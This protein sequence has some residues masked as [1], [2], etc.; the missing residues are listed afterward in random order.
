MPEAKALQTTGYL[1]KEEI[2]KYINGVEYIIMAAPAPEYFSQ[3]PIHFTIF[4]NT[5]DNLPPHIAG[6]VLEKFLR[7]HSISQPQNLLSQLMGV[8][9]GIGNHDTHMPLLI[10]KPQDLVQIPHT[11]MF[12]MDFLADSN[13]FNEV[14]EHSLSG[15]TYKY[16]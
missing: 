14:K 9:F 13:N 4:L 11:T 3:T 2:D 6:A 15:W 1:N 7:E 10:I 5:A 8:G 16:N 12:V